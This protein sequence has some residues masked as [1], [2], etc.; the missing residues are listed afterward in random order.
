MNPPLDNPPP[1]AAAA[2]VPIFIEV[3]QGEA[4]PMPDDSP[5]GAN[6]AE[7]HPDS[8]PNFSEESP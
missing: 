4:W 8:K 7:V 2:G 5:L 3:D 6:A 1:V